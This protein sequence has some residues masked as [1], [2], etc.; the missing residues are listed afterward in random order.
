MKKSITILF[1]ILLLSMKLLANTAT[2]HYN[3]GNDYYKQNFFEKAVEEYSKA[4]AIDQ[5]DIDAYNNRGITYYQLGLYDLAIKDFSV[6][7]NAEP[8]Q[9]FAYQSRAITYNTI[10]KHK[11]ANL[12]YKKVIE[13]NP[14]FGYSYL[15]ILYTSFYISKKELKKSYNNFL[16]NKTKLINKEWIYSIC[17]YITGELKEQELITRAGEDK[18]RLSDAY[19][20]I[21]FNYLRK[22]RKAKARQFFLKCR[23]IKMNDSPEYFLAVFELKKLL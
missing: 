7:I 9:I 16:I 1:T 23:D 20:T 12:D 8:E 10:G 13:I 11:D 22:K 3:K 18:S 15:G 6:V 5:N 21:G 2:F 17:N 14:Q 4:I 19:F